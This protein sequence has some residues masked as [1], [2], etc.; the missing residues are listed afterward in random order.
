MVFERMDDNPGA[1]FL[2]ILASLVVV[3]AGLRAA[4]PIL[5]PF[6]LALFLAVVS[7]PVM[8][9]L[10]MRR[11]PAPA[12]IGLTVL[13]D[14]LLFGLVVLLAANS[15]GNLNEKLPRY[16][17][18]V[19]NLITGWSNWMRGHDV[20]E[21][22]LE[23]LQLERILDPEPIFDF[24]GTT[25]GTVAS[26]FSLGF[27]VALIMVFILAEA[28][29]FPFK[30]QALLGQDRTGRIRIT[31]TIEEVQAY[32]GIKTLVSLATGVVAGFFC[33]L[34]DLDFPILLGLVAFVLN[35]VPTIGSIIAAVPAMVLALILHDLGWMLLVGLGYLGINTLFGN[36]IEPNLMGRRLGLS[37]LVVVLSLIFW[38]WV[39][40]P[41]GALL[42]VP[43]TM[44]LRIVLENTPDLRW[45]AVLL[46]KVPP[47]AREAEARAAELAARRRAKGRGRGRKQAEEGAEG[48][49]RSPP[50]VG[51][52][53]E[54]VEASAAP[55]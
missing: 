29:V 18:A 33:W 52:A 36:L 44:V 17:I 38:G 43:L 42:S 6:S 20:P 16:Q 9:G 30:F 27:L 25:L 5:V 55:G 31:K 15:V 1:R 7:M 40:G 22:Y 51:E 19:E 26:I 37:T 8:F 28:T 46:D 23:Y 41:V 49:S 45:I 53:D 4:A 32:L 10:R 11:V 12:A 13:L 14:V 50:E 47:Q 48:G 21:R 54:G 35:F 2:L 34:M 39:W 3:V 24:V